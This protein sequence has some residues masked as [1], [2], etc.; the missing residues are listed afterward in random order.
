MSGEQTLTAVERARAGLRRLKVEAEREGW[1]AGAAVRLGL[2]PGRVNLL[3][4]HVDYSDGWVMPVAID[5][6]VAAAY[7]PG[8]GTHL[9]V[10]SLDFADTFRID[11]T[12]LEAVGSEPDRFEALVGGANTR[13][14]RYAAGVVLELAAA[15]DVPRPGLMAIAGDVPLGAG[16]SSSAALEA[17]LY[18]ALAADPAASPEAAQLCQRAENRW[19]GMPCGIMDQFASFMGER[20]KVLYLDC[21]TLEF[22]CL[23]LP[24]GL[25]LTVVDSGVRR[26]LAA[27]AYRGRRQEIET[28]CELIGRFTGPIQTLRDVPAGSFSAFEDLL[29][30]PLRSRVEHVLG[31]FDR[32]REGVR[33]LALGQGE[34]FGE[35]MTACHRSLA[36]LY[37]VSIPELDLI[38]ASALE[39]E[40]VL[41]ARL[42]GAGFGGCCVVLHRP[43][44]TAEL[45]GRISSA[46][47]ERF[48]IEPLCH[49][50]AVADGARRL[51]P[52]GEGA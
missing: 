47:R 8:G 21:R 35:L 1:R 26:E 43:D 2:A 40:G 44:C 15:G 39:V 4:E 29:P 36:E 27:S 14:R 50:L 17:A 22:R 12:E 32:V 25:E 37:A 11:L 23:P 51:E 48:D 28:A 3:G 34:A 42:T 18:T 41:G 9:V 20:E 52:E 46:L 49:H 30:E 13:W 38:V 45:T 31:G 33:V 24:P 16:L 7:E 10:H 19:A 6:H 5:R